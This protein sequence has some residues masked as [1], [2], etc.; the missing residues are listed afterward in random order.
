M[1]GFYGG[2]RNSTLLTPETML[3][4]VT[5]LLDSVLSVSWKPMDAG[6][7]GRCSSAAQGT[8]GRYVRAKP[9][10][11]LYVT[12]TIESISYHLNVD[13][14]N[15]IIMTLFAMNGHFRVQIHRPPNC[16]SGFSA[17]PRIEITRY[18]IQRPEIWGNSPMP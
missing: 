8:Y 16:G 1:V 11:L 3:R 15:I 7:L 17:F 18:N 9:S 2:N 10:L 13:F 6:R 14:F 12:A 5:V 4:N